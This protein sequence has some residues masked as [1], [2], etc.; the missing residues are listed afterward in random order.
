M[1]LVHSLGL[2]FVCGLV[3]AGP[4]QRI[5]FYGQVEPILKR[6]CQS[7]HS[8]GKIGPMPLIT[9]EQVR[10]WA[11]AIRES[12]KLR[13]MPPWFADPRFG[14]FANDPSLSPEEVQTIEAWAKG[15]APAGIRS[16]NGVDAVTAPSAAQPDL[17]LTVPKPFRLPA[18]ATIEYQYVILPLPLT[19][20]KWVTRVEVRPSNQSVV[21]HAVLYVREPRTNWLR[22][23]EPGVFYAPSQGD[24]LVRARD[25]KADILAVYAPGAPD[26]VLPE[27][28]AKKIP[29]G[30]DL[31][32]QLHYMSRKTTQTD[33]PSIALTFANAVPSRR[34]LTLQ[35]GRDDLRIPPGDPNF[36]ASVSGTL[37]QETLL[38]SLFP[39]MHL[40]GA[41]F[42]FD[43][44]D[45]NGRF[46]RLLRVKPYRFDWQLN[47]I[48]KTPKLLP[49]GTR[50]RW[51]GYFDN[52]A[53]NPWNPDPSAEVTWGEQSWDEMMI[54]F[55][56]VAVPPDVDKQQ[57]FIR[58]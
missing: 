22:E 23:V 12:V 56:D 9:Y 35:M 37:P 38:I 3:A 25:T 21:H 58:R 53:A 50:L 40:R 20:D 28:M 44:V 39:H 51:T 48:L 6:H 43:M 29:A 55:F 54:G 30:S 27:G 32:L 13:R 45:P 41:A 49:K 17:V 4:A 19:S 2:V 46:E 1:T 36:S 5:T 14:Q 52:S 7:C 57:F 33:R 47:Y 8:P 16:A 24:A 18:G 42:D 15:G 31:V 34:V 11:A 26:V 10:P